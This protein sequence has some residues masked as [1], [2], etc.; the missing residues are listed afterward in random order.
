MYLHPVKTNLFMKSI[1]IIKWYVC[2]CGM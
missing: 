2:S 1:S